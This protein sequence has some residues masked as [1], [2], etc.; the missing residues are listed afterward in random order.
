[1]RIRITNGKLVNPRGESQGNISICDGKIEKIGEPF[2]EYDRVI[3]AKGLVVTPGLIDMHVH[4]REPGY[5]YKETI[6]SGTRAA[7]KG[8]FT[9]VACMPNT[10]PVADNETVVTYI[11]SQAQKAGYAKVYPIACIT[12]G[13]QGEDITEFGRLKEA[14]AVAFSDDGRPVMDSGIM[15]L[16]LQY[17]K[18]FDALMISHSEDLTLLNGGVMNEGDTATAI[19]LK[20]I[21]RA[22][23][24]VMQSRDI[25]LARTYDARVHLAHISTKG[26]V[27]LVRRAKAEGVKVTAET[28]PHYFT[29]D[30]TWVIGYDTNTK[31]NP[32]LRTKE[33]VAAIKAGLADGTIDAIATD[34]AP[35]HE[36]EK[37][38]EYDIAANGISGIESSL[39]LSLNLVREGVISLEHMVEL[40]SCTPAEI[41]GV[42]G[43]VLKEGA[44][45]DI[46][47]FDPGAKYTYTKES[48]ISK[49]KNSPY[50]DM[51]MQGKAVY[52]IVDGKILLDGGKVAEHD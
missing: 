36:D 20:G 1:M 6:L 16:A 28:A 10:N 12:K 4:L 39:P 38:V 17:G 24:E 44:A 7:V 2:G 43:G 42:E 46:T 51:E 45:A 5:E 23:E 34:H 14:G 9:A 33:D 25:I 22:A 15:R 31:V 50:L 35:H 48:M 41:L 49:G 40:L 29:A 11:L 30:D 47:I 13:Q 37:N 52:T 21:T 3:D 18:G 32:P 19:G 27:E 8:G 26:A